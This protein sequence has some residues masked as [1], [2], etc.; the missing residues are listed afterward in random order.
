M[1]GAARP[2][3]VLADREEDEV[4]TDQHV[5]RGS[6]RQILP[7]GGERIAPPSSPAARGARVGVVSLAE[8]A[9][10]TG[11]ARSAAALEAY[12]QAARPDALVMTRGGVGVDLHALA[13]ATA[14]P[15][16]EVVVLERAV[17]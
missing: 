15:E 13:G 9:A 2:S 3:G 17:L 10:R 16:L 8:A 11:L 14:T 5:K 12:L 1:V 4:S 6:A 7:A